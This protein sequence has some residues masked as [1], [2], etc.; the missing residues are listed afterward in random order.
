MSHLRRFMHDTKFAKNSSKPCK[1]VIL[2]SKWML[3]LE[4]LARLRNRKIIEAK[5]Y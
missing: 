5:Q 2:V 3:V 1:P 4:D